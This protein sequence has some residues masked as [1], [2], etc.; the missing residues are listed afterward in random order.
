MTTGQIIDAEDVL[1][2]EKRKYYNFALDRL[3]NLFTY[4]ADIPEQLLETHA[5]L[6]ERTIDEYVLNEC[7]E[8]T[9]AGN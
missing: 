6:L 9:K 5:M 3:E 1:I 2:V 4:G 8:E 7:G